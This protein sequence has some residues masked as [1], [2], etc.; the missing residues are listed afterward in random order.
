MTDGPVQRETMRGWVLALTFLLSVCVTPGLRAQADNTAEAALNRAMDLEGSNKCREAIP[1]FR[2][3]LAMEDPAGAVLGLERCYHAVGRPDSLVPVLDSLLGR[4]PRDPTLR[5]IQMR[6][7]SAIRAERA[8]QQAFEGWAAIAPQDPVPYRTYARVLLDEGRALAADSVLTGAVARLGGTREVAAELAQMRAALGMWVVSARNWREASGDL[9]YLEQAAVFSLVPAPLGVRDSLRAVLRED[10]VVLGAR[11]ILAGLEI[12]WN[13][14]RDAWLALAALPPSDSVTQ[15]WVDFAQEAEASEAWLT[16]RDA[17]AQ[18]ARQRPAD[19]GLALRAA[20]AALSGGDPFSTLEL[21]TPLA[22]VGDSSLG[23]AVTVLRV[24]AL[25]ALGRPKEIEQIVT[26]RAAL[27]DGEPAR[28]AQRALAWAWIRVGDLAK[29]KRALLAAGAD[30]EEDERIAAWIALFEGDLATARLGLKRND[31]NSRD[32]VT[33]MALLARTRADSSAEVGNAFLA[34]SRRDT[35]AA[36]RL[37]RRAAS[38]LTDATPWLLGAAAR[39]SL[40]G[41]DTVR[42]IELWTVV[43]DEHPEAPEAPEAEL[44]WARVLR[45]NGDTAGAIGKLEHLILT[46]PRSALVPQARVELQLS[47]SEQ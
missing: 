40:A 19:R 33:A 16:A 24:R 23:P 34:L 31:E 36:A 25:S 12:R 1:L 44:E 27:L 41:R 46:Y 7:L 37:F 9:S 43:L 4:R 29:S 32:V 15:A 10:P 47:K 2:Q 22:A 18:S 39:F 42:A 20:T 13:A 6:T 3:A 28:Q 38:Q 45:R 11:R 30:G 21:L 35:L 14:P 26:E 17:Y 8:L 5:A